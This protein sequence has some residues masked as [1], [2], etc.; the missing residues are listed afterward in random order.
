M[1]G[2]YYEGGGKIVNLN[3]RIFNDDPESIFKT[4]Y[5]FS[6]VRLELIMRTACLTGQTA[7]SGLA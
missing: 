2:S 4:A 7:R 1:I 3:C 5:G 6:G